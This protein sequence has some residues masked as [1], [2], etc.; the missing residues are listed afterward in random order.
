MEKTPELSAAAL[1][2]IIPSG[3]IGFIG[4]DLDR[5][6]RGTVLDE[7]YFEGDRRRPY[8]YRYTALMLFSAGIAALGLMNDSAA[9]VIGA[10]LV[11]P[12]MTPIMAFASAL[13]QTWSRRVLESFLIVVSGAFLGISVGWVTSLIIPRIGPD[14]PLPEQVLARTSPNLADLGIALL[15]G[16]AGAYVTVRTEA[17]SALPGVGI[18]VAL[19]PPLATVGITLGAERGE[20]AFGALLLFVTNFAAITLAAGLTF[21]FAGF[22]PPRERL[23][24]RAFGLVA[25]TLLVLAV[26]VPLGFNSYYKIER[27]QAEVVVVR[28]VNDWD[29]ALT[30]QKV[31]LDPKSDPTTVVVVVSGATMEENPAGLA[32]EIASATDEAIELQ[33]IFEPVTKIT[34]NP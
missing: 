18:A 5:E 22:T 14:T 17:G 30:V 6:Q 24:Q 27:S 31:I 15:A 13:I 32:A 21:A 3:D 7:L 20:L 33:L 10:M 2:G 34:A 12:L 28:A 23:R 11:A 29:P 8:L 9:V 1:S 26:A 4:R 16:A 25:T 19:V